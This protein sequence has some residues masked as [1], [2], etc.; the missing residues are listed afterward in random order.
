MAVATFIVWGVIC[1]THIRFRQALVIQGQNPEDLPYRASLY[2][3]GTYLALAANIFLIFFQ[4]YTAFLNP[5]SAEDFVIAYILLPV[6]LL[7]VIVYKFWKQ[8]KFVNLAEMDIWSGRR[9]YSEDELD[10]K[11]RTWWQAV[12]SIAAG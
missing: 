9:E 4:G 12:K 6:F 7:F 10:D 5:F 3:Y 1:I 8:T 11:P 2:P